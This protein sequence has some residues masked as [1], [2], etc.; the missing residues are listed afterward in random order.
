MRVC[1]TNLGCKLNQA[2]LEQLARDFVGA[3]YRVTR[4]LTE[5][6]LHVVNSCTVT[7]VAARDSRKVARRGRRVNPRIRT[8]LTGCY[9][10]ENEDAA[11]K[12]TGA[13]LIVSNRDKADLVAA[14]ESE[15]PEMVRRVAEESVNGAPY[16]PI[17]FGNARAL[18]K[19]EDGC[20]MHCSFCIIPRTRGPQRSRSPEEIRADVDR[21]AA[22]GFPEVVVTGVQI[23]A[24][25]HHGTG[26]YDLTAQLLERTRVG[27]LR[28][29]SIA[30]WHFDGRLLDLFE[31]GRL[32]RHFHLSLQSGS[33]ATLARM[34]RPYRAEEFRDLVGRIRRRVPGIAI[35]TDV[36]AGFP[37]ETDREFEHSADFVREMAFARVH[38]FPYS[39][40]PKTE[41][42]SLNDPVPD[43]VKK[44][45]V[46]RL[47]AIAA[48]AERAF[49][50]GQIGQPAEVVWETR[51]RGLWHGT[52]DNYVRVTTSSEAELTRRLTRS[53]LTARS[54]D[55]ATTTPG[56]APIQG[57]EHAA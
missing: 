38:V 36:I 22:G 45:R 5:A 33:T 16:A 37:G 21:L 6:D 8:V 20:N 7:H 49:I 27:R 31:S 43:P 29:T 51:R 4:E 26:L 18:V 34:K 9:A 15:F 12:A 13:D 56:T 11:R 40:R 14:V 42:A 17:E 47:R 57:A 28:L 53:V 2:E 44:E 19:I 25:R 55:T 23:S 41:A 46:V 35:T 3:G 54:N 1:F 10:A 52:S 39:S 48:D 32:C 24:Y 30:P 50:D